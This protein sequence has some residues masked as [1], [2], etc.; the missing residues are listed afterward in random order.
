MSLKAEVTIIESQ[1]AGVPLDAFVI[2]AAQKAF[3]FAAKTDK[4]NVKR[5]Y[6]MEDASTFINV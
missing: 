2:K 4:L 6:A 1:F 5:V 3:K